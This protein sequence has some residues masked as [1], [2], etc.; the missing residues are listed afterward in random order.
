MSQAKEAGDS[1]LYG[2]W[3]VFVAAAGL[4]MGYGPVVSFTFGVFFKLLNQE[5]GWSRGDISQAFSISLLMMSLAF[6][7]I[8]RLVDRFGSVFE[9]AEAN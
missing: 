4:F 6:P 1:F 7:F 3:I 2:W 8:G 5:F 9:L